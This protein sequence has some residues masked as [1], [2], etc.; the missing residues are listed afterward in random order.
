MAGMIH[1]HVS[2]WAVALILF[3]V[4]YFLLKA[5]K[6]KGHK[7]VNMILRLFYVLILVTGG[8]MVVLY[9]TG[10][11]QAWVILK[12][13]FGI[14]V[15]GGMEAVIG[16]TKRGASAGGMWLMLLISFIIVLYLGYGIL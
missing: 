9:M 12:A 5:G 7:I 2:S 4:S 11:F 10:G 13:L 6:E 14:I 3:I 8:Y 16:K 1:A 15:I